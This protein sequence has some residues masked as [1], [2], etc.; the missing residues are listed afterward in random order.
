MPRMPFDSGVPL[1]PCDVTEAALGVKKTIVCEFVTA[2]SHWYDP[3][4]FFYR[5][6][7]Y[8][9]ALGAARDNLEAMKWF[10]LAWRTLPSCHAVQCIDCLPG[11]TGDLAG[12]RLAVA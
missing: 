1:A 5:G 3:K 7:C 8:A 4:A 12:R 9:S 10:Q 11:L 6:V 2:N